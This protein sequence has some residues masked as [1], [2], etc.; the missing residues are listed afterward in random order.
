MLFSCWQ[1][2]AIQ[3]TYFKIIKRNHAS[4]WTFFLLYH[5]TSMSFID[6]IDFYIRDPFNFATFAIGHFTFTIYAD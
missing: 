1:F 4:D 6:C 3:D 2:R 5:V